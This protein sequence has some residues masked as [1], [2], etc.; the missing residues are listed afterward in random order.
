MDHNRFW[1]EEHGA[2]EAASAS[3]SH[4]SSLAAGFARRLEFKLTTLFFPQV[5]NNAP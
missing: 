5:P 4:T 3:Q 2:K 1:V